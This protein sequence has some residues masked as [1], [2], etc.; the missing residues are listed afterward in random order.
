MRHGY[1]N[2]TERRAG[3]VYKTYDGPDARQRC[4]AGLR[5]LTRLHRVVP[6]PA[7]ELRRRVMLIRCRWL[8]AFCRRWDPDGASVRQWQARA[9][10]TESWVAHPGGS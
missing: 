9:V 6:V 8:E 4:A 1:T 3:V 2:V 5:A 10:A 7:G